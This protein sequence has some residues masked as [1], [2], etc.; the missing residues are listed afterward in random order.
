MTDQQVARL[1]EEFR[2]PL[3][4]RRHCAAVANFACELGRKLIA[5]GEKVDL[6]L[7]RHAALLHD[8][9]R[10]VDFRKFK[11]EE[12]P[13]PV[14][15]EDVSFWKILR[16]KYKGMH[17]AD[18]GAQILTERGFSETAKLVSRHR[19]L[20]IKD[21]FDSWEEKLLYYA[22]KRTK[23]DHVVDLQERLDDGRKRNVPGMEYTEEARGLDEKVFA[24][25]REILTKIGEQ[26]QS[27]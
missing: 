14:T 10:V 8:L 5:A 27:D 21:G 4:V 26:R 23:H 17:H 25:E 1:I 19:F 3:H 12:F 9:V 7:L 15:P 2:M 18:A 13:D 22:D 24:L 11:P 6:T 20:Q 16:E